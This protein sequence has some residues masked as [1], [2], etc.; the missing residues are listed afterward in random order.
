MSAMRVYSPPW[1][2]LTG[3]KLTNS[4]K[5]IKGPHRDFKYVRCYD[6][7]MM[8]WGMDRVRQQLGEA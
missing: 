1:L 5:E 8:A 7:E 2:I 4:L 3:H 6:T